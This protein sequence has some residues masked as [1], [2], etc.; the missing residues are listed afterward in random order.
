M[1]NYGVYADGKFVYS[2]R[3]KFNKDDLGYREIIKTIYKPYIIKTICGV[4]CGNISKIKP[5]HRV[6]IKRN[7]QDSY[8][9]HHALTHTGECNCN[10]D[11]FTVANID[12]RE[13]NCI[14]YRVDYSLDYIQF[15]S[16]A[17][18]KIGIHYSQ[19]MGIP[20]DDKKY[21]HIY[22]NELFLIDLIL[23]YVTPGNR[24]LREISNNYKIH[25]V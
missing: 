24:K 22:L 18:N 8:D 16:K 1:S 15:Y 9:I 23:K 6:Q 11:M 21:K 2:G 7:E 10:L 3:D 19:M 20:L 5:E 25:L 13:P 4:N 12:K 17:Y 14:S